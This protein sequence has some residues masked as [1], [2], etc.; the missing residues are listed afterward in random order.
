MLQY[1][2]D[3]FSF[4][5]ILLLITLILGIFS[6]QILYSEQIAFSASQDLLGKVTLVRQLRP[7]LNQASFLSRMAKERKMNLTLVLNLPDPIKLDSFIEE[8]HNE[9]SSQYHKWITPKDFGQRFG[10]E[11]TKYQAMVNWLESEGFEVTHTWPNRLAIDFQGNVGEIEKVFNLELNHYLFEEKEYFAPN[12]APEIP[13]EFATEILMIS[14]LENFSEPEPLVKIPQGNNQVR[15]SSQTTNENTSN[16]TFNGR[17]SLA[18]KDFQVAYNT[19]PLITQ[20]IDGTGQD[21][22]IAARSDFNISDVQ[23]FRANFGL[24]EKDPQKVF[25]FGTVA[26]RGGIEETEVLLD[27]ELS[28]AVAPK[29][30]I[31]VV[32]APTINQSLQAIYNNFPNIPIVSLSFGLCEQRLMDSVQAFNMLY[33]QGVTQGQTTFVASGDDGANDCRD[34][35]LAVNG[36]ASSPNVVAVGGTRLNPLFNASGEATGYGG[37]VVWNTGRGGGGGF[38]T[39]YQRPVFQV[40]TGVPRDNKRAIP[41]VTLMADPTGP[42]YFIVQGGIT[43]VIGG[44]SAS[45]PS[46]AAI[47]TLAE[48]FNKGVRLGNANFRIYALGANQAV[49]GP[50]VFNDVTTGNNSSG[51]VTGFTAQPNFD[52]ASGW[53]SVNATDFAINLFSQKNDFQPVKGLE[54]TPQGTDKVSLKWQ[55]PATSMLTSQNIDLSE[56]ENSGQDQFF[57]SKTGKFI[58]YRFG[59]VRS[60]IE[61]AP[62]PLLAGQ[63]PQISQLQV[64]LKGKNKANASFTVADP[65]GDLGAR[66]GVSIVLLGKDIKPITAPRNGSLLLFG[67]KAVFNKPLDFTGQTSGTFPFTL[68]GVKAFPSAAIWASSIRDDAGFLNLAPKVA[69]IIGRNNATGSAPMIMNS[70]AAIFDKDDTVG[71][72]IDG[73]DNE[74]D[75]VGM[76]LGF[77]DATNRVVFAIGIVGDSGLQNFSPFTLDLVR[78]PV[79]GQSKFN[80]N[81]SISGLLKEVR[82]G[83]LKAVSV[84]LVDSAGNQSAVKVIALAGVTQTNNLLRYNVYR[85]ANAPVLLSPLNLIATVPVTMTSFVDSVSVTNK[86]TFNY[87]V[88]AVYEN[89]ESTA[90]NEV[91][92]TI[93][94]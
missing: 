8:L 92:V 38:S 52:L 33:A 54:A 88:T 51:G 60:Q 71:V 66:S 7:E 81:F 64:S 14:G 36:L 41:D 45:A 39:V 85:S 19:A 6:T 89:G 61:N 17:T 70:N 13:V 58:P 29:A 93:N 83:T 74:A 16:F 72:N 43:T 57:I 26:N 35:R 34:G 50:K 4:K 78:S 21:I 76:T 59:I 75:T 49:G 2:L 84:S 65:D 31:Q 86:A 55:A 53:G 15:Q 40:G 20:G 10:V 44:T 37:E 56:L 80:I 87:V 47:L 62:N 23:R 22:A 77:L 82:V 79:Q 25:P 12:Y 18:P 69:P 94:K 67:D 68:K 46:W 24:S 28:G 27:T 73:V 32:I 3:T 9:K 11:E 30:N 91:V 63:P 5:K 48:Q 90:S 42:G 1:R